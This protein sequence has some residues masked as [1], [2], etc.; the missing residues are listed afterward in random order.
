MN[1]IIIWFKILLQ[2]VT[3]KILLPIILARLIFNHKN[4]F[5]YIRKMQTIKKILMI[6]KKQLIIIKIL[7]III[8]QTQ[9]LIIVE[10]LIN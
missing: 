3:I 8:T 4:K 7:K 10:M 5:K 9:L 1:Q 6:H 2:S